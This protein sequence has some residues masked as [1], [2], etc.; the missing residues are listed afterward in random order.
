[1]IL[2]APTILGFPDNGFRRFVIDFGYPPS[3]F[4]GDFFLVF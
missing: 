4:A 1:M 3:L 2:S